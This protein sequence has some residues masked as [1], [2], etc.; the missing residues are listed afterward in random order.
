MNLIDDLIAELKYARKTIPESDKKSLM[1]LA[2]IFWASG[3][4]YT[5]IKI[6]GEVQK[7]FQMIKDEEFKRMVKIFYPL[8]YMEKVYKYSYDF[9]VDPF[10]ILAIIRQ[11]SL[12]ISSWSNGSIPTDACYSGTNFTG[13]R[14]PGF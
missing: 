12:F 9:G 14:K 13:R 8:P 4:Y 10:L 6:L 2:E 3:D 11:E 5:S 7:S 1:N